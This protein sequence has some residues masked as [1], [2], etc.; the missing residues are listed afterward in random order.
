MLNIVKFLFLIYLFLNT[1]TAD[2]NIYADFSAIQ[3]TN[4]KTEYITN[5]QNQTVFEISKKQDL[6]FIKNEEN[7]Q[8]NPSIKKDNSRNV[9]IKHC[10][11]KYFSFCTDDSF[12]INSISEIAYNNYYSPEHS[13]QKRAP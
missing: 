10:F 9:A 6:F 1:L 3:S 7:E 5:K 2:A 13:I 12:N 11:N 8:I 4:T